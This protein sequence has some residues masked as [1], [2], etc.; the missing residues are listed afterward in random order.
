[1]ESKIECN[2][3][4]RY[5]YI[6]IAYN[7]IVLKL[8]I[9]Y[10]HFSD[11]NNYECDDILIKEVKKIIDFGEEKTEIFNK[12]QTDSK[13]YIKLNEEYQNLFKLKNFKDL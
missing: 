11:N 5:N 12:M 13:N 7:Y 2:D 3:L 10:S 4:L 8:R 1:M 6:T 9:L